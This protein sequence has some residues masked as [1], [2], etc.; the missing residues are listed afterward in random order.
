VQLDPETFAE[1]VGQA[2]DLALVPILERLAVAEA[3]VSALSDV[4]DRVLTMETK[5]AFVP[6]VVE[7]AVPV[8][9]DLGPVLERLTAAETRVTILGDL[10]DRVIVLETKGAQAPVADPAIGELRERLL[11]IETKA[12]TVASDV[13]AAHQAIAT[14]TTSTSTVAETLRVAHEGALEPLRDRL[15]VVETKAATV[16]PVV[17]VDTTPPVVVLER[18]A[19]VEARLDVVNDLA[20]DVRDIRERV[21]VAEVR[22]LIPG[23]AGAAGLP[24]KDGVDGVG[25]DDLSVELEDDRTVSVKARRGDRVKDVGSLTLPLDIYRGV[26][27]EG[28]SYERGDGVTWAGSEWH[29]HENTTTKPGE[30]SKAWTLKVKRGRDGR[31]GRDAPGAL[32]VVSVGAK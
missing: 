16:P 6:P 7:T 32:P 27:V 19:S 11:V 30:G 22:A 23:P 5:A 2:V 24:G 13:N 4:R 29:C 25:F 28:K 1:A 14:L 10:R 17:T 12:V 26:Y 20:K 18:L 21:A 9:P 31:D 3:R 8:V 15:A